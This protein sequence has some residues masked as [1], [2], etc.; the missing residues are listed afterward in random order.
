M[1]R[2]AHGSQSP[3]LL[4]PERQAFKSYNRCLATPLKL[5]IDR[6]GTKIQQARWQRTALDGSFMGSRTR[7]DGEYQLWTR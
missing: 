2:S 5:V 4:V 3:R 6:L 7:R 1:V